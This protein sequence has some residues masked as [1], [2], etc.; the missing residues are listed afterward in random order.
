MMRILTIV[1]CIGVMTASCKKEPGPGGTSII[2]GKVLV[3]DYNQTFTTLWAE[4]DGADRD[5]YII[6]GNNPTYNDRV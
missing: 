3:E 2:R 1:F 5:V 4:Y 6:Y